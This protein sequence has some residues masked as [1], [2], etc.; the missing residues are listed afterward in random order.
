VAAAFLAAG[1]CPVVMADPAAAGRIVF[2]CEHGNVK[3]L[4][5]SRWFDRLA[6]ARGLALRSVSRGLSP[7]GGVPVPIAGHLRSDGFDVAG[8]RPR[9]L[10]PED[11]V[12]SRLVL[13]G[14]D[15]PPWVPREAA[16]VRWDGIPPAS[17]RYEDSRDALRERIGALLDS[18]DGRVP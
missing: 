18:L 15:P 10:E 17:E 13:I 16:V 7:E 14:A 5:A 8:F 11:L 6:A 4:I 3:S 2:V 1:V 9:A 12:G